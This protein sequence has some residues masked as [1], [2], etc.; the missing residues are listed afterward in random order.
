MKK[1]TVFGM[2]ALVIVGLIVSMSAVSAYRGDYTIEGPYC[3]D[4]RHEAMETAF[5]SLDYAAWHELMTE[6]GR[7]P[8]V[9]DV[10]T[11]SNFETFVQAHEAGKN[12]DSE[13]AAQLRSELSLNN[14]Q[15]PGDGN[16]HGKG[17]SQY[18]EQKTMH[19][20]FAEC[21]G[22]CEFKGFGHGRK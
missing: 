5:G 6:D 3:D 9:A 7:Y 10:V 8:R 1:I 16:G 21:D 11:E 15:G 2:S 13:T 19:N 17:M 20:G 22:N 4:E 14:G 12:G 18:K